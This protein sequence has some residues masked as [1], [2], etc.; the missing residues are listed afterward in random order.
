MNT[1]TPLRPQPTV[2]FGRVQDVPFMLNIPSPQTPTPPHWV[3]PSNPVV[4]RL[5]PQ[6]ESR[7]VDMAEPSPPRPSREP[8]ENKENEDEGS[9]RRIATGGLR[10]VFKARL[11]RK[12][13][14]DRSANKSRI[15]M[16]ED[17]DE[18]DAES[19]DDTQSRLTKA[20]NHYTLNV[21]PS[22]SLQSDKSNELLG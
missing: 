4:A 6:P 21:A 20:S 1:V 15:E 19:D 11:R 13:R 9:K 12:E 3:P 10:R 17:E 7:D 2:T 16:E 22:N 5:F 8:L 18:S 14:S